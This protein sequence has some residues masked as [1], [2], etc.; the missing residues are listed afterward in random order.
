MKDTVLKIFEESAKVKMAFAREHADLILE[1]ASLLVQAFQRGG[2][3]LLFGNGGSAT[4]ASHIAGEFVN[5]F[6]I[7]RPGLP[8]IALTTD[9]AVLTSISNDSSFQEV[10]ARQIKTLGREGDVAVG[11]STSGNSHNILR[12]IEAARDKRLRT[13]GF[14][15]GNGGKLATM[16]EF[17]FIVPSQ[18]VPRIQEAHITLGHTLCQLVDETLFGHGKRAAAKETP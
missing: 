13:V 16:A 18:S 8:A 1:V 4:D 12:G 3:V 5:R 2:K 10:F 14:T 11:I 6:L 7:D 17:T 9:P 15:G